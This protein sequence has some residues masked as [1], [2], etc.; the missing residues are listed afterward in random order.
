MTFKYRINFPACDGHK[1][2]R[3]R[4]WA[5]ENLPNVDYKLPPQAPIRTTTLTV[6]FR[7]EADR[8]AARSAFPATLP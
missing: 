5:R 7:S 6:S 3:F 4:A 8:E 2:A 1:I